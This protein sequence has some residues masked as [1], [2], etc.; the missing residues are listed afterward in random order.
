MSRAFNRLEVNLVPKNLQHIHFNYGALKE[1]IEILKEG[2]SDSRLAIET[3]KLEHAGDAAGVG[4]SSSTGGSGG[5]GGRLFPGADPATL[6]RS[7]TMKSVYGG[8]PRAGT[9]KR[10]RRL[11]PAPITVHSPLYG[12]TQIKQGGGVSK[13]V[14]SVIN[15][16]DREALTSGHVRPRTSAS[17]S[18]LS[19]AD[20]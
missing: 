6:Q 11:L 5:G 13:Y 16:V 17:A 1:R 20:G 4:S 12:Q 2:L 7:S 3:A 9:P 18:S 19:S 8:S 14:T 10:P 15:Y